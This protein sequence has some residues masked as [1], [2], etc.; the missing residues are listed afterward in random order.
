LEG[1]A[2]VLIVVIFRNVFEATEEHHENIILG[3]GLADIRTRYISNKRYGSTALSVGGFGDVD[4][5]LLG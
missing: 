2:S 5:C 3:D 4:G 1:K